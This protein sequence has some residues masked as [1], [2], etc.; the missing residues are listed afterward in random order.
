MPTPAE[1]KALLFLASV[2]LLGASVRALRAI[3]TIERRPPS[4][5]RALEAQLSAVDSAR[6][7]KQA[8]GPRGKAR[9]RHRLPPDT[10]SGSDV[11]AERRSPNGKPHAAL[12]LSRI[13]VDLA[14]ASQLDVLPGVGPALARRIVVD[15]ER[16]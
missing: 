10:L 16:R 2:A 4:D 12:P 6:R 11:I 13:D 15:R 7:V 1:K 8:K 9:G 14:T 3:G 5:S